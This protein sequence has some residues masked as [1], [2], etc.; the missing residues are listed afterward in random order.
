MTSQPSSLMLDVS[1]LI[2]TEPGMAAQLGGKSLSK[3]S[4]L[5]PKTGTFEAAGLSINNLI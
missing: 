4:W 5:T 3:D 1:L 2:A